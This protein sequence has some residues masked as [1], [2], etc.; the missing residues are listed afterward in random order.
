MR[1]LE[2]FRKFAKIAS[3]WRDFTER[4]RLAYTQLYDSG[5]WRIHYN[6]TDFQRRL[7][8]VVAT[9]KRWD[10]LALLYVSDPK[11]P[12]AA[13]PQNQPQNP[14]RQRPAA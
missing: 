7:R 13:K 11:S 8:E 4:R 6:Q 3:R 5:D 12:T 10:E 14:P 2:S 9:A 1:Q